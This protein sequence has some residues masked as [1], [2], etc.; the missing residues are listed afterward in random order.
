MASPSRTASSSEVAGTVATTGLFVAITSVADPGQDLDVPTVAD[1]S[2]DEGYVTN[3]PM[4]VVRVMV[5]NIDEAG[6]HW[7]RLQWGGA[8]AGNKC[9]KK[10]ISGS[11]P[12]L[13]IDRELIARGSAI[14]IWA[15]VANEVNAKI[16]KWPY[17]GGAP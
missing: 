7:V 1:A 12:Q 17:R 10:L 6:D 3:P 8:G 5:V 13:L 9:S 14:K 15:D 11:G 2:G 4:D 16:T